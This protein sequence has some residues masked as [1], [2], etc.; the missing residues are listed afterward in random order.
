M[1]SVQVLSQRLQLGPI[2]TNLGGVESPFTEFRVS[3]YAAPDQPQPCP[4][5]RRTWTPFSCWEP[6]VESSLL[7]SWFYTATWR[8]S[9]TCPQDPWVL[10]V[11]QISLRRAGALEGKSPSPLVKC[12]P[13]TL[14]L[15]SPQRQSW[16]QSV[17][18]PAL[19]EAS[20]PAEKTQPCLYVYSNS[21][22]HLH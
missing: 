8:A 13:F 18:E 17:M 5:E 11:K 6:S 16:A 20:A 15:C 7:V 21:G 2:P 19:E 1:S 12:S 22:L 3:A 14:C 4:A 9:L 10:H